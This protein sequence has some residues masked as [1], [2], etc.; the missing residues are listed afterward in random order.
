MKEV[1]KRR[2]SII[3]KSPIISI[4]IMPCD[5]EMVGEPR[6]SIFTV[7]LSPIN[8]HLVSERTLIAFASLMLTVSTGFVASL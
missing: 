6:P 3:Y 5:K 8:V 1:L 4:L 2:I 7:P